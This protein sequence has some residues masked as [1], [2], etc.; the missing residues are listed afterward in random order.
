[1]QTLK[2]CWNQLLGTAAHTLQKLSLDFCKVLLCNQSIRAVTSDPYQQ[3]IA[4]CRIGT[5]GIQVSVF[6]VR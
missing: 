1:M 4:K 5:L 3:L 6:L 2:L